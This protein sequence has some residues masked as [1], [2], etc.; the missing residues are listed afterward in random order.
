MS[1]RFPRLIGPY[2]VER[3]VGG[4]G[5]ATVLLARH[6]LLGRMV[7]VKMRRREDGPDEALLAERFRHGAALQAELDHPHVARVFDYLE[8]P[9]FQAIVLEYLPGGSIED[10]L[11]AMGGPLPVDRAV[12]IGIRAAD[13]MA[14]AHEKG[15]VHRDIKP[16]NVMLVDGEDTTTTRITDFGVA[17]ALERSP[18]LTVAGANVGTLWYMPP[19][20]FNH[21]RPTPL[22]DVY[23]LGATL[24][25]MLTGHIPFA[26]PDTAEIFRRFLDRVP[27]PAIEGRNPQVP[28]ALAHVVEMAL[29]L[30]PAER[31]PSAASLALLLRAVAER[32]R[33]AVDDGAARR[34][35]HQA[36]D[37]EVESLRA[38]LAGG[39]R[40]GHAVLDALDALRIRVE[41][42]PFTRVNLT[43]ALLEG[44]LDLATSPLDV[45]DEAEPFE[46]TRDDLFD[47]DDDHTVVMGPLPDD[48]DDDG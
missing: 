22:V 4:G 46:A 27:P 33:M 20:Q 9:Q 42:G 11:R 35:L 38:V 41:T 43:P 28:P 24:Y 2:A 36:G 21:E 10:A 29:A 7:A 26:A 19:E 34:L 48:D 12:D 30:D 14:Y 32:E 23:A 13:A 17:K 44:P 40:P 25:E 5:M 8:S 16:G 45:L 3:I 47:E 6:R 18:D 1:S 31:V 37:D 39:Q 15:V